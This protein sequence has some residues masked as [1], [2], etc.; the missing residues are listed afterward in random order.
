MFEFNRKRIYALFFFVY[1]L[2]PIFE[3]YFFNYIPLFYLDIL[4]YSSIE[5]AFVQLFP[6]I[7]LIISPF[8]SY[9]YDR[10]VKKEIQS[11]ILLYSSCFLLCGSFL[12]FILFKDIAFAILASKPTA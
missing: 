1:C 10:Y 12:T 11:K 9:F 5:L 3:F 4:K 2:I 6:Y 7:S 8:L